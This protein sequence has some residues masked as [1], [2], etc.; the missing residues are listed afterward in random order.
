MNSQCNEKVIQYSSV[1]KLVH[2]S[3]LMGCLIFLTWTIEIHANEIRLT[4]D[5]IEQSVVESVQEY[6]KIKK[7]AVDRRCNYE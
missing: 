2:L 3:F 7:V 4:P 1:Y 6:A 5:Q